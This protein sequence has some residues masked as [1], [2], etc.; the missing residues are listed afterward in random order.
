MP[1]TI[2]L[3]SLEG[4]QRTPVLDDK[5]VMSWPWMQW[6]ITLFRILAYL[7]I[8]TGAPEAKVTA[9]VGTLFLRLDGGA[10]TTLYV[11]ESGIGNTGW[12]G[13]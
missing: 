1:V 2:N 12:V 10:N 4:L 5:G 11:K 6:F 7:K 9:P 13:K 3:S 8:G